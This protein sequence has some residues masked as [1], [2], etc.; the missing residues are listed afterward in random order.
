M[1]IGVARGAKSTG[2]ME[3]ERGGPDLLRRTEIW[4]VE[5]QLSTGNGDGKDPDWIDNSS[6]AKSE[7][8]SGEH[9]EKIKETMGLA[10]ER[11]LRKR[12]KKT[13]GKVCTYIAPTNR[14]TDRNTKG[15]DT[16]RSSRV[17]RSTARNT[18]CQVLKG[19]A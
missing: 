10:S 8:N 3:D 17:H 4:A 11:T 2:A 15:K 1:A 5:A 16:K 12:K 6:N 13:D 9:S 14:R 7:M 18:G 19:F